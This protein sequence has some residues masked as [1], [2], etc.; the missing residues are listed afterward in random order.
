MSVAFR[1][2]GITEC[3]FSLRSEEEGLIA[4]CLDIALS[5]K[6]ESLGLPHHVHLSGQNDW[7]RSR[8][9]KGDFSQPGFPSSR[10]RSQLHQAGDTAGG[11]AVKEHMY[12]SF[13]KSNSCFSK[14][15]NKPL[16]P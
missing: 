9:S 1:A 10:S 4:N 8:E 14:L 6:P 13:I 16:A 12:P 3:L 11:H 15:V 2:A 5:I 7:L